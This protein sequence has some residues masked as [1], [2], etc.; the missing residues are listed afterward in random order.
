[1]WESK[2][3]LFAPESKLIANF[4]YSVE[5]LV[6][7]PLI[8]IQLFLHIDYMSWKAR[9][10]MSELQSISVLAARLWETMDRLVSNFRSKD[11]LFLSKAVE[12][13]CR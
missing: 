2:T 5:T 6:I 4:V 3:N 1:M 7:C 12:A 11:K 9:I 8:F 10:F 13:T